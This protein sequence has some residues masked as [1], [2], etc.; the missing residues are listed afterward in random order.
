M[1]DRIQIAVT[2]QSG[3]H[4]SVQ[5]TP[6]MVTVPA[7]PWGALDQCDRSETAP[8]GRRILADRDWRQDPVLRHADKRKDRG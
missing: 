6:A 3:T 2:N 8:R 1:T 7:P 5:I 4:S